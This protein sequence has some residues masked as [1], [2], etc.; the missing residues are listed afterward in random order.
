MAEITCSM[1]NHTFDPSEHLRCT[2]CPIK[3]GCQLVCCPNCGFETVNLEQSSL[4][5]FAF[6]LISSFKTGENQN[7]FEQAHS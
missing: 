1:C 4:V 3:K 5:R 7:D 6:R 2:E